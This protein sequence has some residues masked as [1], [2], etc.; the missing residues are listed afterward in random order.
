MNPIMFIVLLFS[1]TIPYFTNKQNTRSLYPEKTLNEKIDELCIA[2]APIII[3]LM[4]FTLIF[5][6][7]WVFAPVFSTESNLYYYHMGDL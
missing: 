4:I 6:I 2:L 1:N 5:M 7:L 3:L